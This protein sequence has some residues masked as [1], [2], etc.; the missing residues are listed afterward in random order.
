MIS[1]ISPTYREWP[2]IAFTINGIIN[3]MAKV[4]GHYDTATDEYEIIVVADGGV[5]PEFRRLMDSNHMKAHNAKLIERPLDAHPRSAALARNIGAEEAEGD[6][7]WFIDGHILFTPDSV[8]TTLELLKK[9]NVVHLPCS[10]GGINPDRCYHYNLTLEKNF[11][12]TNTPYLKSSEP[13][14]VSAFAHHILAISKDDFQR[15]GGY[16]P[17]FHGYGGEEVYFDFKCW[18]MGLNVMINTYGHLSHVYGV[19]K[20][21]GTNWELRRNLLLGAYVLGGDEWPQKVLD[22]NRENEPDNIYREWVS[23]AEDAKTHAEEERVWLEKNRV[24][25]LGEVLD[26]FRVNDIPM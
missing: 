6:V 25:T 23:A 15:V 20:Y 17:N 13:Y 16:N 9:A 2:R 24:K 3:N 4:D 7:L 12:G 1:F 5:D 21:G 14:E 8:P 19:H 18:M 10:W 26:F 22:W 11:W